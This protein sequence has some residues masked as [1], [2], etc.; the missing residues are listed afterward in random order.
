MQASG[1][2]DRWPFGIDFM[3]IREPVKDENGEYRAY[4][5]D[6]LIEEYNNTAEKQSRNRR[7]KIVFSPS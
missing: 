7:I 6:A 4:V 5:D 3:Q 2:A 1:F